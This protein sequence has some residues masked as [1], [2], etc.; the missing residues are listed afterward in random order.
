MLVRFI[1]TE[2]QWEL[3]DA[4]NLGQKYLVLILRKPLKHLTQLFSVYHH[5]ILVLGR[6][7]KRVCVDANENTLFKF[8]NLH[9]SVYTYKCT[10]NMYYM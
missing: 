6:Q 8:R 3:Q 10:S 4:L 5:L 7:L 1:S 2:P 9:I